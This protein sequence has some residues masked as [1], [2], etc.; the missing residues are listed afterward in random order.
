MVQ[1]S[2]ALGVYELIIF[3]VGYYALFYSLIT[4]G[5]CYPTSCP[6]VSKKMT[7]NIQFIN[8]LEALCW[9]GFELF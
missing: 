8:E 1:Q 9:A 3:V 6:K 5:G 7:Q 4:I 2:K